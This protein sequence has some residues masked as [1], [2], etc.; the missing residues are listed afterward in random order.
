MTTDHSAC[1]PGMISCARQYTA[2]VEAVRPMARDTWAVRVY[3][4]ELAKAIVPGQFFMI[5]PT[6]GSDPLLGRPFALFDV[7][8]DA[9]G[10]QRVSNSGLSRWES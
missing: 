9:D 5:R 4:P 6:T 1:L 10:C 2:T 3:A 7:Y 8:H